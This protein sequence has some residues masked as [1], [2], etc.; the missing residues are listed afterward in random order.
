MHALTLRHPWVWAVAHLGKRIENRTWEPPEDLI[1]KH[2]A[3]HGSVSPKTKPAWNEVA[4][5]VTAIYTRILKKLPDSHVRELRDYF[6]KPGR[7][8]S[9][10]QGGLLRAFGL[11]AG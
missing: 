3:I 5:D 9:T 6:E 2:I 10:A 1:G 8:R 7:S 4:E 11:H